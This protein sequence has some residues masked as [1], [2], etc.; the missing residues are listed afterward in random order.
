MDVESVIYLSL[1]NPHYL[2]S[3]PRHHIYGVGSIGVVFIEYLRRRRKLSSKRCLHEGN[4]A[5]RINVRYWVIRLRYRSRS[6][7]Y[8]SITQR[9]PTISDDIVDMPKPRVRIKPVCIN[10]PTV[11]IIW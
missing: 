5:T 6:V 4:R 7:N 2:C 1:H 8:V 3:T 10:P 9:I 11:D